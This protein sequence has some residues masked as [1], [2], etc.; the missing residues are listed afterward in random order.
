MKLKK[1]QITNNKLQINPKSQKPQ[2]RSNLR[3][4]VNRI[5]STFSGKLKS[6][7]IKTQY[8][9]FDFKLVRRINQRQNRLGHW[10][11]EFVICLL[12]VI[13]SLEFLLAQLSLDILLQ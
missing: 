7:E 2:T 10:S 13:W 1:F 3:V 12:F 6:A 4:L 5:D 11:L 9:G 8:V